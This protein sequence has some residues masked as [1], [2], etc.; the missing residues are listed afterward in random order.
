MADKEQTPAALAKF[1]MAFAVQMLNVGRLEMAN[2][3]FA[4]AN[5]ALDEII[6][7]ES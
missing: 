5:A 1:H 2:D 3:S 7:G 4:K 6:A